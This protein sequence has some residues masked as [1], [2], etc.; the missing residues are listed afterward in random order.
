MFSNASSQAYSKSPPDTVTH[1]R[2]CTQ[3]PDQELKTKQTA[4]PEIDQTM[5]VVRPV[6]YEAA[7]EWLF[8]MDV[9]H[10]LTAVDDRLVRAL[11][12][13]HIRLVN[14]KWVKRQPP[15]SRMRC[16]QD[17]EKLEQ[18][19]EQNVRGGRGHGSVSPYLTPTEAA[20]AIRYGNRCIMALSYGWNSPGNPDPTGMRVY[21]VQRGL[22]NHSHIVGLFWDFGSLYQHLETR[23]RS[24]EE[25]RSF[26]AGIAVM[27]DLYASV[28]G[29]TVFQSTEMPRRPPNMDGLIVAYGLSK[30][31]G[32]Q[33]LENEFS[34]YGLVNI[35][36][37]GRLEA[38]LKFET[39]KNALKAMEAAGA[40]LVC[41]GAFEMFN[42]LDYFKR[43]W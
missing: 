20:Q 24:P 40:S 6:A 14:A 22:K 17:L 39:H 28:I 35:E 43:G 3:T 15:G 12:M 23:K 25:N 30:G 26:K 27:G 38:V 19:Y 11:E 34:K 5:A 1:A 32:Q 41:E 31:V 13:G 42:D 7:E 16:R 21:I 29:T 18:E 4:T 33:A 10:V 36:M 9:Y 37:G 2:A 8:D